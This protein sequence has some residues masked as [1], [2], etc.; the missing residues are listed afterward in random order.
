M[1]IMQSQ[2]VPIAAAVVAGMFT[3]VVVVTW[4]DL[5]L[6]AYGMVFGFFLFLSYQVLLDPEVLLHAVDG[7]PQEDSR[8]RRLSILAS[9]RDD[10][11]KHK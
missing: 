8:P 3:L 7:D 6:V 2:Q 5:S 9:G 1:R 10:L 4:P 11:R